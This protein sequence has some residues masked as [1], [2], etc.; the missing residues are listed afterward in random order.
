MPRVPRAEVF[1]PD[2]ICICHLV[3]RCV[4]RW[5][6]TGL[7]LVTGKDYSFR[8]EMIRARLE[9]LASVFAI[10]V[11]T[12][13]ILSNHLHI[14]ARNRPD[15]VGA[16]S[17]EEVAMRWLR[18][19]P[20]C[21][22]DEFL[23]APTTEQVEALARNKVE[24]AKRRTRLSDFSWFMKALAEPI[25][26]LSN[27]QDKVKGHFWE[28]RFKAQAITDEASLLAVS[29]YVDL[30][31]VRAAMATGPETAMHSSAY[32]RIQGVL[33][34]TIASS[35]VDA[36]AI[37]A[38]EA[39][40][41]RRTTTP[42]E[43]RRRRADAKRKRGKAIL[44]D[45]WLAPLQIDECGEIGP[46]LSQSGVRASD[47]GFLNMGLHAYIELL[48]WILENARDIAV[49]TIPKDLQEVLA[50]SRIDG[51]MLCSMVRNFKRYFGR[52]SAVGLSKSLREHA[53][54]RNKK[55]IPGQR[56]I[57]ELKL[58]R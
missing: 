27:F 22:T 31:P 51:V 32:D 53:E 38:D 18:L 54:S 41:L 55:F 30:N 26:K 1:T 29:V 39:G 45:A 37:G 12:Y 24:V 49:S 58:I 28:E 35:A 11:L 21:K 33:G 8:R 44:R 7:D 50:K 48:K 46:Q 16:W 25:A 47:K 3:Q 13:A 15:I 34:E 4:R 56:A 6:L 57:S 36:V 17:D 14:V 9:R 19:F 5:P 52:G 20:G 40:R 42:E 43:L 2:Q 23:G 10:D